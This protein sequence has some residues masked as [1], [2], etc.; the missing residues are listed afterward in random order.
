MKTESKSELRTPDRF[1]KADVLRLRT[2]LV[3]AT[4]LRWVDELMET[5]SDY[6]V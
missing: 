4:V 5:L 2:K 6:S 3:L 1:D